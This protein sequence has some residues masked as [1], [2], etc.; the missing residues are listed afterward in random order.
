MSG[1]DEFLVKL[2]EIDSLLRN[3]KIVDTHEVGVVDFINEP[4][5]LSKQFMQWEITKKEYLQEA[6][7]LKR[8]EWFLAEMYFFVIHF[9]S[10]KHM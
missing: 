4:K 8:C 3:L 5:E 1:L 10:F 2:W 6:G 9:K 7:I